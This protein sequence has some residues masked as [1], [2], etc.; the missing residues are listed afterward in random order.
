[1]FSAKTDIISKLNQKS[2]VQLLDPISKWMA[3]RRLLWVLRTTPLGTVARRV[4][5]WRAHRVFV[6][7]SEETMHF[8]GIISIHDVLKHLAK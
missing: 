5:E 7:D 6:V 8:A 4:A 3:S 2:F 1:L